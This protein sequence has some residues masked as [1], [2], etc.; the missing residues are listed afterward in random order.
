[1]SEASYEKCKALASGDGL[2]LTAAHCVPG[3]LLAGVTQTARVL[4]D[5]RV[6]TVRLLGAGFV[7]EDAD[8]AEAGG[9]EPEEDWALL[10]VERS[11]DGSGGDD[12]AW[13]V[14]SRWGEAVEGEAAYVVGFPLHYLPEGWKDGLAWADDLRGRWS[15]PTPIVLEG[16]VERV[17]EG[18][19]M[20]RTQGGLGG[21]ARGAS[22]GGVFVRRGG[23]AVLVGIANKSRLRGSLLSGAVVPAAA[24]ERMRGP[25][26]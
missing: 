5:D 10:E 16:R 13:S 4:I 3:E 7:P 9:R 25:A 18:W 2:V 21:R 14:M 24:R 11:G 23:R 20:V 12:R 15:A 1:M 17:G 8:D 19:L 26:R 22:G 6:R